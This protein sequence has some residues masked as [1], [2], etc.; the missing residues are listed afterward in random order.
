MNEPSLVSMPTLT[1]GKLTASIPIIQGG[2]GVGIS[3]SSLAS[4]VAREG[5][6]GIVAAAGIGML[7]EDGTTNYEEA[8]TRR[9]KSEIRKA[10]ALAGARGIIGV[11]IMVAQS[12]YKDL[13]MAAVEAKADLIVSGAGL[14]LSLPEY[15]QGS[16]VMLVPIVSS[17]RSAHV[18]LRRWYERYDR[19]PDAIV[20]E[21]PLAGGHLG[22]KPE[23]LLE[24]TLTLESLLPGVLQ[25]AETFGNLKGVKIPV[26]AA[27][28]V[29]S[30]EDI[31]K[32]LRLGASGV[33]MA[34]RFVATEECDASPAFKQTYI[35]ARK[36]DIVLI[37]SPVGLPGR[38][39][40]NSFLRE[41]SEG[42]RVP[43]RCPFHCIKTCNGQESPY[44]IALALVQAF[45][46][47]F[48]NGFA[49]V[50]ANGY[51]ISE[52]VSV[53]RLMAS[54]KEEYQRVVQNLELLPPLLSPI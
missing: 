53:N 31:Q 14:P 26:I 41:I 24:E 42:L 17:A 12:N 37:K 35:N 32:F 21:G 10:K 36:E 1:I 38:A 11:N 16:E 6:I 40:N 39:I 7:E 47:K 27:G 19:L 25:E 23:E 50:G 13:V 28:G 52:I 5:G 44:C 34:T 51:R 2:M 20:V 30:G 22:F 33:Q 43:L 4:A 8:C 3:L 15:T 54:L 45:H 9:L 18:I 46:G 29:F 49:F 48:K